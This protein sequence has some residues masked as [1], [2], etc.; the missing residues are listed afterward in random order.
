MATIL[1]APTIINVNILYQRYLEQF[2][3]AS[4]EAFYRF[5]LAPTPERRIFLEQ[6][7]T[8]SYVVH[9]SQ[10]VEVKLSL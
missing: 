8:K 2:P 9:D 3:I 5:L 7:C 10:V 6:N 1:T 4:E